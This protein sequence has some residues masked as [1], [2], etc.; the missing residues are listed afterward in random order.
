MLILML[1]LLYRYRPYGQLYMSKRLFII[2]LYMA[3]QSHKIK[4][5]FHKFKIGTGGIFKIVE[6]PHLNEK[7]SGFDENWYTTA[8]WNLMTVTWPILKVLTFEMADGCHIENCVLAVTQQPISV[9]ISTGSIFS[10]EYR[11]WNRYLYVLVL[12]HNLHV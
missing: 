12:L 3:L 7:S 10:T 1:M 5:R 4:S 6:S 9:K 2:L 11:Q 8:F